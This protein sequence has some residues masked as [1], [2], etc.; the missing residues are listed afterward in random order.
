MAEPAAEGQAAEATSSHNGDSP[1]QP[2]RLKFPERSFGRKGEKRSFKAAWFDTWA[3]LDYREVSDSVVCYYCSRAN[4]KNL[5][6]SGL[7]GKREET[8]LTKGF[9]NWKDA[10]ASFRKHEASKYHTDAVQVVSR[11][12]NNVGDMLSK[13]YSEQKKLNGRMLMIILQNIQHLGRQGLALRGHNDEESNFTQ[14]L[15]L[16]S[17]D[18]PDI[19]EW[20]AR[21]GGD[22]YTS[23]EIQYELLTLMCHAVLRV[24]ATQLQQAEFFTLMTDECVDHAN[25]EQLAICFRYVNKNLEVHEEFIGLYECANITADTIV[26]VLKDT[27]L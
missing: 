24:V 3:W 18:Q 7:Y 6:T 27:L 5:L 13:A 9:V 26:K 11:P 15:K 21:K 22:K 23:P 2:R 1:H 16:R 17:H 4:D 25:K 14:L 20:L 10:C 8:F 19:G 12:Q